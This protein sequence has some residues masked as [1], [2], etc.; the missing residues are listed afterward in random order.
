MGLVGEAAGPPGGRG[1]IGHPRNCRGG[2]RGDGGQCRVGRR[3]WDD[4][5]G[6]LSED[7]GELEEGG[8]LGETQSWERGC[9]GRMKECC[10]EILGGG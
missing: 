4:G 2:W 6:D 5:C 9:V 1:L 7:V 3:K 8:A 10:K